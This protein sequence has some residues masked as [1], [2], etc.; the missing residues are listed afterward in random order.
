[1]CLLGISIQRMLQIN[2]LN[3]SI[4]PQKT[5]IFLVLN[6]A[7]L[8]R[9]FCLGIFI[10]GYHDQHSFARTQSALLHYVREST[11][12]YGTLPSEIVQLER[13]RFL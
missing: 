3:Q 5:V 4:K 6:D 11:W 10:I 7:P 8:L 9:R 12:V 13:R 2:K 1:M